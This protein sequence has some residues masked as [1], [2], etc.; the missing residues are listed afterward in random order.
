M[1]AAIVTKHVVTETLYASAVK[2]ISFTEIVVLT[3][4]K[5]EHFSYEGGCGVRISRQLK[6]SGTGYE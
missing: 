5:T 1:G 2:A 4:N 6:S 3:N